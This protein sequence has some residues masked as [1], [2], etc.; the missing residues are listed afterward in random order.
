MSITPPTVKTVAL[1]T[2]IAS[3]PSI[4]KCGPLGVAWIVVTY[5]R[6]TPPRRCLRIH[7]TSVKGRAVYRR[8]VS[9]VPRTPAS[10]G[11][12]QARIV[13]PM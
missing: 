3:G 11:S 1:A 4:L 5:M 10:T 7:V 12:F 6:K 13:T 2:S 9:A 8:N